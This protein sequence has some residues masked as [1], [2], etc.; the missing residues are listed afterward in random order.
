MT[1]ELDHTIVP[2]HDKVESAK[3]FARIF[4][5]KALRGGETGRRS[6]CRQAFAENIREQHR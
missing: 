6:T 1:I 4:S 5:A 2:A 3:F